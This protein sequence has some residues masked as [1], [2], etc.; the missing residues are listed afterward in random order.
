[1]GVVDGERPSPFERPASTARAPTVPHIT[2]RLLCFS[3]LHLVHILHTRDMVLSVRFAKQ[4]CCMVVIYTG[5]I[6]IT[7]QNNS[8]VTLTSLILSWAALFSSHASVLFFN[9]SRSLCG[10]SLPFSVYFFFKPLLYSGFLKGAILAVPLSTRKKCLKPT[11]R[12]CAI[13]QARSLCID[14]LY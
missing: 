14:S 9:S 10:I 13:S 5:A 3:Q 12:L 1:M 4:M 7:T 11:F 6:M 8:Q 2:F